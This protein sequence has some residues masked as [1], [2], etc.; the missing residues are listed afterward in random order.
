MSFRLAL[1]PRQ[2]P[3]LATEALMQ[4]RLKLVL[5]NSSLLVETSRGHED[6]Q[7]I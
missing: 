3:A 2:K 4:A 7:I 5:V 6:F 1:Q